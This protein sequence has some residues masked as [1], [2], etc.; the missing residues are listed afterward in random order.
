MID[1]RISSLERKAEEE[2]NYVKVLRGKFGKQRYYSL[3]KDA[4]LKLFTP[5]E[6][7]SLGGCGSKNY[8]VF[9]GNLQTELKKGLKSMRDLLSEGEKKYLTTQLD[10]FTRTLNM[11]FDEGVKTGIS[12][13]L[14]E[15]A[16]K[17]WL[18][19]QMPLKS[20]IPIHK[21]IGVSLRF[22]SKRELHKVTSKRKLIS[23]TEKALI[24]PSL[25]PEVKIEDFWGCIEAGVLLCVVA[26]FLGVWSIEAVGV[27]SGE[28]DENASK[29]IRDIFGAVDELSVNE[30]LQQISEIVK[31]INS[32]EAKVRALNSQLLRVKELSMT[33]EQIN[34]PGIFRFFDPD[35]GKKIKEN[36]NRS[37]VALNEGL[38]AAPERFL[39]RSLLGRKTDFESVI[40]WF[41]RTYNEIF[42]PSVVE[43][44]FEEMIKIFPE[45][46]SDSLEEARWIGVLARENDPPKVYFIPQIERTLSR[47][48]GIVKDCLKTVSVMVYDIRGS[49]IMG[50][51]LLN[52]EMEDQ[53]RNEFQ[54]EL[55]KAVEDTGGFFVKDTGDGG[56]VLFSEESSD[57]SFRQI[58]MSGNEKKEAE[59]KE[60]NLKASL[61]SACRAIRCARKMLEYSERFVRKNLKRYQEWF[62][63][64]DVKGIDFGGITYERFPPEYKKIFQIGIGIASGK[65]GED[66][67][68]GRNVLGRLDLTGNLIRR[69]N[70]YSTVHH[71]DRSVIL[72]GASTMFSFL[73]NAG[74]F[75]PATDEKK[76]EKSS[77]LSMQKKL[78]EEVLLWMKG[79]SGSYF[80]SEYKVALQRIDY[81]LDEGGKERKVEV[82]D[83]SVGVK[84]GIHF[85]DSKVREERV[86]Y[87]VIPESGR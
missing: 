64:F 80:M 9:S 15:F 41:I 85:F 59:Y 43:L 6:L 7:D 39:S 45:T 54:A 11:I 84:K 73:L 83:E 38:G 20:A 78:I 34:V 14:I 27:G 42:L 17:R 63:E 82:P 57:F 13:I 79:L 67:Y 70:M 65:P 21:K 75:K 86:L 19:V 5:A 3:L 8:I 26:D 77:Y 33:Q 36:I 32:G 28:L 47:G 52:A 1:E 30:I 16:L 35:F 81:L 68:L 44:I 10:D 61:D 22:F 29:K 40:D 24:V 18:K 46:E 37:K 53:I 74:S 69:A 60:I 87:E 76:I 50:E 71:P 55:I 48:E 4:L 25:L 56:I 66:I 72:I 62:K 58:S 49:S 2:S 51:R 12:P 23:L 31:Y